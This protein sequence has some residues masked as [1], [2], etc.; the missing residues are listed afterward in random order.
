MWC[1]LWMPRDDGLAAGEWRKVELLAA[2]AVEQGKEDDA[3]GGINHR[4]EQQM[5]REKRNGLV[6]QEALREHVNRLVKVEEEKGE[7]KTAHGMLCID[8]RAGSGSDIS[9]QSFC[10]AVEADGI[11]VAEPVLKHPDRR[12]EQQARHWI[13]SAHAE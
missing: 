9:H 11:V 12:A 13:A 6:E 8:A 5:E 7:H 10:D 4:F 1:C 3:D 2:K